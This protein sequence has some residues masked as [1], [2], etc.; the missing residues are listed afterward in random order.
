MRLRLWCQ[1]TRQE[2]RAILTGLPNRIYCQ[3]RLWSVINNYLDYTSVAPHKHRSSEL[4]MSFSAR[5]TCGGR[6]GFASDSLA[7]LQADKFCTLSGDLFRLHLKIPWASSQPITSSESTGC[8]R[9][10]MHWCNPAS[11]WGGSWWLSWGSPTYVK[12][13]W[14][15][16]SEDK[17]SLPVPRRQI[18]QTARP[19]TRW[20]PLREELEHFP[21]LFPFPTQ[22]LGAALNLH[23]VLICILKQICRWLSTEVVCLWDGVGMLAFV[24][25]STLLLFLSLLWSAGL[26]LSILLAL[27]VLLAQQLEKRPMHFSW[28]GPAGVRLTWA[29]SHYAVHEPCPKRQL[30]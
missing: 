23:S 2:T 24:N 26:H 16:S 8:F 1:A 5:L 22:L 7:A 30:L 29:R 21:S 13:M 14:F 11:A 6:P 27:L 18:R 10:F 4:H 15:P 28:G 3:H 17:C 19:P 25:K 9:K 20:S 12:Y